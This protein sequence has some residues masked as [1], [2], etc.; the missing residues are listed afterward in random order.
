M[1]GLKISLM[2]FITSNTMENICWRVIKYLL[3]LSPRKLR[4]GEREKLFNRERWQSGRMRRSRKPFSAYRWNGG[5]NPPLSA[6]QMQTIR[7]LADGFVFLNKRTKPVLWSLR[8][9]TKPPVSLLLTGGLHLLYR[10]LPSG[11][12]PRNQ[13]W[14][15]SNPKYSP[16]WIKWTHPPRPSLLRKEGSSLSD[17]NKLKPVGFA[18]ALQ[19]PPQGITT[20]ESKVTR[21]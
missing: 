1:S 2:I 8:G 18:F 10:D 16:L 3:F 13:R 9:K 14:R 20:E 11:S 19:G 5:S 12:R 21:E 15:G 6:K 4:K 7:Q 17:R